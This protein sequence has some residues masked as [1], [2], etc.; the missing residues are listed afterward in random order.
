[1]PATATTLQKR[2]RLEDILENLP[3]TGTEHYRK[4]QTIYGPDDLSAKIYLV[5]TG[6][7][8][9]SQIAEDGRELLLELLRPDELFGESGFLGDPGRF[10]KAMAIERA[11]L[12]SWAISDVEALI[13]RRPPLAVALLHFLAQRNASLTRRIESLS[14]DTV[15]RRLA[16]S[17]IRLSERLGTPKDDG[18]VRM[19]PITHGLLSRYVGT[20][21]EIVTLHMNRFRKQGYVSYSR[22]GISLCRGR[23]R[24]VLDGPGVSSAQA[25]S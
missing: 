20:T 14:I 23:L 5:I 10:D 16:R 21:R 15:E 1:M 3:V 13:G 19:M 4:G 6:T 8:G 9:I 17:L 2:T 12:M 11:E 22:K 18:S 7:V 24:A 25:C